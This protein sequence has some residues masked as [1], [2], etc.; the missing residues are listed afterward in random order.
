MITKIG[1]RNSLL[2]IESVSD[3]HA[4]K[5]DCQAENKAGTTIYSTELKVI[6]VFA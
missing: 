4:G 6:G 1:K 3:Q 5:Y 2:T